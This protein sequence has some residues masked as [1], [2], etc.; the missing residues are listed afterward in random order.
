MDRSTENG[1]IILEVSLAVFLI[2]NIFILANEGIRRLGTE[3][4]T[5]RFQPNER[6]ITVKN[7]ND[8][9]AKK[10][11]HRRRADRNKNW[12]LKKSPKNK[13]RSQHKAKLP[14]RRHRQQES[15]ARSKAQGR[16]QRLN[17]TWSRNRRSFPNRG[18]SRI[19]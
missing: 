6:A 4:S 16:R 13:R 5:Y 1:Q 9:Q 19:R 12:E 11:N 2:V 7:P 3:Q 18:K 8:S 10:F 17:Q 15:K 14:P